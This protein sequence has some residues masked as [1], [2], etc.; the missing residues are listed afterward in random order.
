MT[1]QCKECPVCRG[2]GSIHLPLHHDVSV[3]Q[4][5]D[6]MPIM[7]ESSRLYDC[8]ECVSKVPYRRIAACRVVALMDAD[9]Q[10]ETK[11]W[12]KENAA[13]RM[14]ADIARRL[15]DEGY[16][17]FEEIPEQEFHRGGMSALIRV[18][19]KKDVATFEQRV[20]ARQMEIVDELALEAK[21]QIDNWGSYYGWEQI[22]KAEAHRQIDD[23]VKAVRRRR[24]K[25]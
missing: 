10:P 8:P 15:I 11:K 3:H 19:A 24:A 6:D 17:E 2:R 22:S 4:L 14:A 23:A 16:V 7:V 5:Q 9:M 18:V 20:A 12:W 13:K 1:E 21:S 25:T